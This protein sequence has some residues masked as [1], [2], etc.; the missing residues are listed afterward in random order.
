M[1]EDTATLSSSFNREDPK[2]FDTSYR[3][4]LHLHYHSRPNQ[5]PLPYVRCL[6]HFFG[7]GE[8]K[9][10]RAIGK[11][12]R[13]QYHLEGFFLKMVFFSHRYVWENTF[14]FQWKFFLLEQPLPFSPLI[15]PITIALQL[16]GRTKFFLSKLDDRIL[17]S[18]NFSEG[19][20]AT[21]FQ[22]CTV[23]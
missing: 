14:S 11:N 20:Q 18:L 4:E 22:Y 6:N 12:E 19:R 7:V 2:A 13:R 5:K 17:S 15:S 21:F 9:Y 10:F 8:V 16:S 23:Q 3:I 1:E